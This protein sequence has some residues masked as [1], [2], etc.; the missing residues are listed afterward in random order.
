[1][2]ITTAGW[3]RVA[4]L[5][6]FLFPGVA[7]GQDEGPAPRVAHTGVYHRGLKMVVVFGGKD[8]TEAELNDLWGWD[9]SQWHLLD[10]GLGGPPPRARHSMGYDRVGDRIVV[11]GG[12]TIESDLGD[13]WTWSENRWSLLEDDAPG[14][15]SHHQMA[16]DPQSQKMLLYGGGRDASGFGSDVWIL[17]EGGWTRSGSSLRPGRVLA[18]M[19]ATDSEVL[20]FGGLIRGQPRSSELWEWRNGDWR[21]LEGEGPPGRIYP[22]ITCCDAES[23]LLLF[24]GEGEQGLLDDLWRWE[25]SRWARVDTDGVPPARTEHVLVWDEE[26]DV[27][28]LFGGKTKE[29]P[30]DDLWEWDGAKWL[31]I[32]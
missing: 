11:H 8:S 27:A 4:C 21:L 24:G 25:E 23:N 14:L 10:D 32:R 1:M 3:V 18:G 5:G 26:R 2:S 22:G 30:S 29:G 13:T 7:S 31:H 15:K 28:V 16:Y 9:G 6:L 12:G 20:L 19:T 17:E